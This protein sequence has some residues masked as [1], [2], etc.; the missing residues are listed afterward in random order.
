[1]RV[2]TSRWTPTAGWSLA[3]P[4]TPDTTVQLVLSFGPEEH[5]TA[6][7]F[8]TIADR[9][10]AAHHLYASGGGQIADG[11]VDDLHTVVTAVSFAHASVRPVVRDAVHVD[12]SQAV[13]TDMGAELAA[14][15]GLRHVLMFAEGITM[16]AAAFLQGLNPMLP[17]GVKVTGGLASN[18]TQ[19]TRSVIGLNDTPTEGRVVALA[20]I[21]ESLRIGTGSVGGWDV[22]GPE[23]IVTR[24]TVSNVFE[25]DGERALDVYSRYLGTFA[26][27]LPGS[28]LLFPLAVRAYKNGPVSVRTLLA[29]DHA[30]GSMR[31]A[32]DI[33][34]GSIV[35]LMRTTTDKLIDGA[36]QAAELAHAGL[37]AHP[38]DGVT[39]DDATLTLCISCIGRRAVMRSRVEEEIEEVGRLSGSAAVV[40]FYSNGEIAPPTD[41]LEFA[42]AVLHNQT[43][44]V[45]TISES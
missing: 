13:G 37:T 36:A 19:L 26:Q 21:G 9:Y 43:M 40:G 23:R 6:A 33:P 24:A 11:V 20:L 38:V 7:W 28:G 8:E 17:S 29:I 25:L 39:T 1:M 45:T 12:N 18:G 34:T 41:G 31:F 32:G 14:I 22:F 42:T 15:P 30:E 27:E 35:R 4:D 2:R 44:T 16:N 10:P 3:L 5:P